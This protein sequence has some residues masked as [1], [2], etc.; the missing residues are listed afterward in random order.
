MLS[1]RTVYGV[2]DRLRGDN[3]VPQNY[4]YGVSGSLGGNNVVTQKCLWC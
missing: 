2:S 1:H 3:F 4:L